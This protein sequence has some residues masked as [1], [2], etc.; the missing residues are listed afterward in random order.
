M[1]FFFSGIKAGLC[2]GAEK[3]YEFQQCHKEFSDIFFNEN[4]AI[5]GT[6][7]P[8]HSS[9]EQC[10]QHSDVTCHAYFKYDMY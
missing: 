5:H 4:K 10:S 7:N 1:S 9:D 6:E 2:V 3:V 8:L